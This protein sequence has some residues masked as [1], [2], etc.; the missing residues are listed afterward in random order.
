MKTK[1]LSNEQ[2]WVHPLCT[3]KSRMLGQMAKVLFALLTN[4]E[5]KRQIHEQRRVWANGDVSSM[6]D[7][8]VPYDL[9]TSQYLV[10]VLVIGSGS[11]IT[12][13]S[14]PTVSPLSFLLSSPFPF[15]SSCFV[16]QLSGVP[17]CDSDLPPLHPPHPPAPGRW[18]S[19]PWSNASA[20]AVLLPERYCEVL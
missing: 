13:V 6:A 11:L 2:I 3:A 17:V 20:T 4:M 18:P 9:M 19:F 7:N 14:S 5:K 12:P 15:L 16:G 8:K 1:Y 10:L